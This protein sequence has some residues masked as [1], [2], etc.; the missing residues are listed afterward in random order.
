VGLEGTV[1]GMHTFGQSAPFKD[2]EE[3]F[4]FTPKR[5]AAVAREAVGAKA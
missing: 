3:E 5:I 4:G 1:V 2:V